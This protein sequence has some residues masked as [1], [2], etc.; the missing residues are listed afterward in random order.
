M[1]DLSR[2]YLLLALG[3]AALGTLVALLAIRAVW[4][5]RRGRP[6][7]NARSPDPD[8]VDEI[9]LEDDA[10]IE[11][12]TSATEDLRPPSPPR[13]GVVALR[14]ADPGFSEPELGAELQALFVS[15]W[16]ERAT[17]ALG[18]LTPRFSDGAA[19]SF[20]AGHAVLSAMREVLADAPV[21]VSAGVEDPW[22]HI[23]ADLTAIVSGVWG[24]EARDFLVRERWALTRPA[25]GGVPWSVRAILDREQGPL[26]RPPLERGHELD[27]G[28][29]LPTVVA[30]D[31][32]DRRD[33]LLARHPGLDLDAFLGWA[34]ELFVRVQTA[35]DAGDPD[36][37]GVLV[38]PD[39]RAAFEFAAARLARV[40]LRARVADTTVEAVE[41]CRVDRDGRYDLLTA[42]I[43][44]R[45]RRWIEDEAGQLVDGAREDQHEISEYWTFLRPALGEAPLARGRQGFTLWRVEADEAYNG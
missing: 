28:E 43:R 7:F 21:I 24:G 11:G 9:G 8:L 19:E 14:E 34:P 16:T 44:A 2:Y 41:L 42:R 35:L 1:E 36:A 10:E 13:V 38:T 5:A 12:P 40:G 30:P 23:T 45:L 18:S 20:L 4:T 27:V 22:A 25:T 17:G 37:L 32:A 15:A 31:L 33:D 39:R 29:T 26:T 3:G 6:G